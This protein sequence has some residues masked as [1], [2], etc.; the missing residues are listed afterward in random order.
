MYVATT[1]KTFLATFLRDIKIII[2]LLTSILL[3]LTKITFIIDL[4]T[5]KDFACNYICVHMYDVYSLIFYKS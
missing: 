2:P 4:Q 1:F 5:F 3:L